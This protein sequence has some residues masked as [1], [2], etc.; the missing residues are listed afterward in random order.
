MLPSGMRAD[1]WAVLRIFDRSFG[2]FFR[3]QVLVSLLVGL[4][5]Y[6]GFKFL[7]RLGAPDSPYFILFAVLAGLFQ[8]IPEV[9]PLINIVLVTLVA[10]RINTELALSV[11]LLSLAIQL[12][13]GNLVKGRI[14]ERII[15]VNPALLVLFIVAL[16]QLGFLWLFFAAPVAGMA[17]DLFRYFL[18][19]AE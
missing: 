6:L 3:G 4:V 1:F 10:S 13:F 7:V 12:V 18:R 9:G 8:L 16:G 5:T 2:R 19:Q 11:L 14:E 17:R 15:D